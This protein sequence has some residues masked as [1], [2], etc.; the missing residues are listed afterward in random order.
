MRIA[1]PSDVNVPE[2]GGTALV[3]IERVSGTLA[4]GS[5]TVTLA[6][7]DGS[8]QRKE[9]ILA[10][11]CAGRLFSKSF[12]LQNLMTTQCGVWIWCTTLLTR[13]N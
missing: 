8:A 3:C 11:V 13:T 6:T 2:D 9:T 5:V 7:S 4:R 12:F 10:V 1:P